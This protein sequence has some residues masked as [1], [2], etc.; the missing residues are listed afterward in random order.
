MSGTPASYT[1]MHYD[2][3]AQL[4]GG[5]VDTSGLVSGSAKLEN[6][7]PYG[8]S[9]IGLMQ[10]LDALL[11]VAHLNPYALAT[12]YDPTAPA[13][14]LTQAVEMMS[15]LKTKL[16]EFYSPTLIEDETNKIYEALSSVTENTTDGIIDQLEEKKQTELLAQANRLNTRFTNYDSMNSSSRL[17]YLALLEIE[18]DRSVDELRAQLNVERLNKATELA[19]THI[20][21]RRVE[22]SSF[23]Q[24]LQIMN[25][26][27]DLYIRSASGYENQKLRVAVEDHFWEPKLHEFGFKGISALNGAALIPDQ[28]N[29]VLEATSAVAGIL[30]TIIPAIAAVA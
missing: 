14:P 23:V 30:G 6:Y 19:R 7:T 17:I 10:D 4:L 11:G 16:E 21:T 13:E 20:D 26:T 12:P 22:F 1:D 24:A 15:M 27:V 8:D 5:T 18:K 29:K 9:N 28:P 25:Q 3:M 2:T